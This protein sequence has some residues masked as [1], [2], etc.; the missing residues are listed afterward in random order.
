VAFPQFTLFSVSSRKGR[1]MAKRKAKGKMSAAKKRANKALVVKCLTDPK[2]RKLLEEKPAA[3]I[4]VKSISAAQ[5][6]EIRLVLATVKG[7]NAHISA[8][9]DN[10]LCVNGGGCGIAVA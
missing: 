9:A 1:K 2:F 6:A 3:A 5:D 10:L 4:G 8:M 7:I